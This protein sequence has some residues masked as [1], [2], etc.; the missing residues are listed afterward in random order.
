MFP[1]KVCR[2]SDNRRVSAHCVF[3]IMI[4]VNVYVILDY[5]HYSLFIY[6]NDSDGP[7]ICNKKKNVS[8]KR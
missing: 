4:Y 5:R 7:L 3:C 6:P 1:I 2:A 8:D